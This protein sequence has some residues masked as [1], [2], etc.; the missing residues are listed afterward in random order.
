[1]VPTVLFLHRAAKNSNMENEFNTSS[2]RHILSQAQMGD[3]KRWLSR[4]GLTSCRE[5]I[6]KS[7]WAHGKK[8]RHPDPQRKAIV[9]FQPKQGRKLFTYNYFLLG[10][11]WKLL[12]AQLSAVV[13]SGGN[14]TLQCVSRQKYH[15][16]CRRTHQL[17]WTLDSQYNQFT[18][19]FQ[20]LFSVNQPEVEMQISKLWQ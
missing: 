10:T 9:S 13:A 18:S 8:H 5:R 11:Y 12:L 4:L 15:S 1:M 2:L 6:W 3:S 17:S 14:V 16:E 20:A 7:N 19:K